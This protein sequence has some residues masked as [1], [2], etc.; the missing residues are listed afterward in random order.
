MWASVVYVFS[1]LKFWLVPYFS[2]WVI[3]TT[4]S[5]IK[6]EIVLN[7]NIV[8]QVMGFRL[9]KTNSTNDKFYVLLNKL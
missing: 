1:R 2:L 4:E 3:P 8:T 6:F 5:K 7:L 9:N